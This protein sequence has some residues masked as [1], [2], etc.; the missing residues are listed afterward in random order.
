MHSILGAASTDF[1]FSTA[2][3]RQVRQTIAI[4]ENK[5]GRTRPPYV[6]CGIVSFVISQNCFF[7][8]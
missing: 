3:D 2:V 8:S 4:R 1:T 5:A 6:I 7:F